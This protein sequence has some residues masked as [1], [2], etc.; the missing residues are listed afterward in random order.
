[1]SWTGFDIS[2]APDVEPVTTAEVKTE[3]RL[4][5]TDHDTMISNKIIACRM[6]AEAYLH[7]ALIT[8]TIVAYWTDFEARMEL[9]YGNAQSV[10][11]IKYLDGDGT[12]QTLA[13]TRYRAD[14]KS[15]APWIGLEYNQS[16]PTTRGVSNSIEVTYVAGYG[17]TSAAVPEPIRAAIIALCCDLYEHPEYSPEI[18]LYN[19][20]TAQSMLDAR[21]RITWV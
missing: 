3:L 9:P 21:R 5:T 8:Q 11:H 15:L 4:T 12:Q 20:K 13:A 7:R 17:A 2:D 1:M 10:T 16:W 19:N 18:A 14:L 6:A